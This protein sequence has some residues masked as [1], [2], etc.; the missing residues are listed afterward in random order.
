MLEVIN[1]AKRERDIEPTHR[2]RSQVVNR[3]PP[4]L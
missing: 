3:K 4:E 2:S 1:E